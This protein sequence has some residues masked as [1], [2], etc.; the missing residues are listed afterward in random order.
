MCGEKHTI[1]TESVLSLQ[2]KMI[3]I[4]SGKLHASLQ[5]TPKF[6]E[7]VSTFLLLVFANSDLGF[8]V[9]PA[10]WIAKASSTMVKV[11]FV[12]FFM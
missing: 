11:I 3:S 12:G 10:F 6:M 5:S 8:H 2:H 1:N 4:Q 7:V 9:K